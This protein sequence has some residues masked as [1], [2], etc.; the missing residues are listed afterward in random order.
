[1]VRLKA[2]LLQGYPAVQ[3][4]RIEA[5]LREYLIGKEPGE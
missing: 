5:A 2:C 1:V 3:V 4:T